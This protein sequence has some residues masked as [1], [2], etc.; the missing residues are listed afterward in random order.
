VVSF[1]LVFSQGASPEEKA[2]PLALVKPC[3]WV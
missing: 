2:V 1:I 3:V